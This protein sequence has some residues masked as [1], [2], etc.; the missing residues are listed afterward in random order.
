MSLIRRLG[1]MLLTLLIASFVIFGSLYLAPGDPVTFLI[2]NPENL[3]PERIAEVRAQYNL[4]DPFLVQYI[5]WLTSVLQGDLGTSF[6]YQQPV[7]SLMASKLPN[8]VFLV[9]LTALIFIVVG[10][11]L[12][13][14][15]AL[16]RGTGTDSA[17]T[18][19]TTFAASVPNFVIS[20]V[21]IFVF[22]VQLRWF[23]VAGD[24]DDFLDRLHHL[25]L[26]ALALAAGSLATI[27][28]VTRQ[29]MIDNIKAE[30]VD[31]ARSFGLPTR[32]IVFRHVFRNAL[33]PVLTMGG[34]IIAGMLGG[35]VIIESVFGLN[36]VGSLLVSSIN[37]HDFP[38]VQAV[39]L[40][41]VIAYMAVTTLVDLLYPLIDART[42]QRSE[43]V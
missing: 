13:A 7:A 27:S 9:L 43:S 5:D 4:D 35:T 14:V 39:L 41:M 21:L 19:I 8:T 37:A 3:T 24:G 15:S 34:L 1:V 33:G 11:S 28:R 6:V 10:V 23:P 36:G 2:G 29:S 30:H 40:Y 42:A 26:P 31:V 18:G 17:I 22:G 12:G 20:L 38:V 32:T 25:V 16:R